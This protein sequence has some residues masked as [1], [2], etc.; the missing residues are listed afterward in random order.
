MAIKKELIILLLAVVVL[1]IRVY[2]FNSLPKPYKNGD[3]IR[4]TGKVSS[5]TINYEKSQRIVVGR[6]KIYLPFLPE[7]NYGDEIVVE[8][9]IK[10]GILE[11]PVIVNFQESKGMIYTLRNKLIDVYLKS[12]PVREASL[13]AGIVIGSKKNLPPSFWEQLKRSGTAHVVVASGMNVTLVAGFLMS[14]ALTFINRRKAVLLVLLGIWLYAL[15]AGFE[16]PIIRAAIMGSIAFLS[17]ELG[18]VYLAARATVLSA[19]F[20]IFINPAWIADV[21]FILSFCATFSLVIFGEKIRS[22]TSKLVKFRYVPTILINDLS[23]TLSAQIGVVPVL[24]YY[25]GNFNLLSPVINVLVLWTIPII[26]VIGII[27]GFL[28]LLYFDLGRLVILMG[29]PVIR[30][31][32]YVVDVFS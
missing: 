17:Q 6:V 11:D 7:I 31:F 32:T 2:L 25:F 30:W 22:I 12:L 13:V 9:I 18:K 21:G 26:T 28:G 10:D 15:I 16:A 20:M 14:F 4:I 1:F 27:A 5:E 23:T 24:Y 3:R 19:I 29:Y 8:G